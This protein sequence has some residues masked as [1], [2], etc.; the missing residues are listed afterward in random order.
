MM[1]VAIEHGTKAWRRRSRAVQ[2]AV[3]AAWLVGAAV[4]VLCAKLWRGDFR[5]GRR[6]VHVT[7]RR[8]GHI[9]PPRLT[10]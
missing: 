5:G 7:C 6:N 2:L 4:F 3:W 10:S 9:S 8:D 1:A